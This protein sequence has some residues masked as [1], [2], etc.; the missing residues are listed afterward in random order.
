L[1]ATAAALVFVAPAAAS[2]R[3]PG[4]EKQGL[5]AMARTFDWPAAGTIT[6]PFSSYHHGIDI[7]MLRSLTVIS[8]AGGRVESIGYVNGFEGYGNV[9][10]IKVAPHVLALYAHLLSFSVHRGERIRMGQVLGVAGCTG[11]C[12]GTHLHFEMRVNGVAVDPRYFLR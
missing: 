11:M 12:T 7:A 5:A 10:I 8:A 9:V 1:A 3:V 2:H 4:I 6:T